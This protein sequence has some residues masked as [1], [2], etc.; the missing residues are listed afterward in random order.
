VAACRAYEDARIDAT[1]EELV[2][3]QAWWEK[4]AFRAADPELPNVFL[5]RQG[6]DLVIS[7]DEFPTETRSFMIPYGAEVTSTRF[8]IPILRRLIGGRLDKIEVEPKIKKR[9][10]SVT[11][12]DGFRVLR[13]TFSDVT[14]QWLID[15][16]FSDEDAREMALTGHAK[17]PVVGL[18]RS[19]QGSK[20]RVADFETIWDMLQPNQ[21]NSFKSLR[22]IA[23]GM[24][25][26][27]D[28]REPWRSGY[29]LARLV[30]AELNH[31]E[32]GYFDIEAAVGQMGIDVR[33]VSLTDQAILAACVGS[34]QFVPLIAIN[35]DCDDSKG[36][37]G[38]RITLAH[39]LC[40]LLFDRSRMQS[41]AR[42][43]GGAADSD[44]LIEMRA[45]AFAVELLA[46]IMTFVKPDGTLSTEDEAERLSAQ[47]E[48]S[49][50]AIRRHVRN[51]RSMKFEPPDRQAS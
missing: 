33:D 2:E 32:T 20:I 7:W 9:V 19:A 6:D 28:T 34:P 43:E 18:L 51:H 36:P 17:H 22:A 30:R 5:E 23:K 48:I 10:L 16:R 11:P 44:R 1:H 37:S 47:L 15:H 39:E 49:A 12:G 4:H 35:T 21:G 3:L 26:Q 27:V 40:H 24:N 31:A 29:H 41:F 42:F 25:S 50:V 46:P 8:A 14:S 13:A 38:R 45:N